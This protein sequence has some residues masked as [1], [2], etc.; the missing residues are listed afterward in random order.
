MTSY[1]TAIQ[2]LIGE[3]KRLPGIGP[4]SELDEE[5]GKKVA[6]VLFIEVPK[7]EIEVRHQG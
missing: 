2:E 7:V 6:A 4:R 1:P 3:L 5:R